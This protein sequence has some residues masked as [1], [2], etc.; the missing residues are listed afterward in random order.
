[1]QIISGKYRARKLIGVDAETTRPTLARVKESIFNLVQG[2]ISGRI[3]LDLFSGSGAFGLECVSR[4]AKKVYMVDK[5]QK[6]INT[7]KI[8]SKNMIEDFEIIK[9]DYLSALESFKNKNIKF[10]LIYLDPPYKSDY[11]VKSLE[12]ISMYNLL[13]NDG[14]IIVE[15]EQENDLQIIPKC[16]IIEKSRKYGIAYI[17]ILSQT[18]E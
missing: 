18:K 3:V 6:A 13:N 2:K 11:A 12:L 7:I 5:E 1:M 17:D 10:D 14:I 15:H 8:N 16:Y 4:F 9:S